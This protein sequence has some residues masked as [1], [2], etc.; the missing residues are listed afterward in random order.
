[1]CYPISEPFPKQPALTGEHLFNSVIGNL[2]KVERNSFETHPIE[3][4]PV[5]VKV[6]YHEVSTL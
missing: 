2:R 3:M 6:V 5:F 4:R 1:M